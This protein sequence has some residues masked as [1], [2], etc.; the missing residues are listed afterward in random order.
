MI[1]VQSFMPYLTGGAG[2]FLI[3]FVVSALSLIPLMKAKDT[4]TRL[5]WAQAHLF[6]LLFPL[7]W[8]FFF[9]TCETIFMQ[10]A[11]HRLLYVTGLA[12]LSVSMIAI[13]SIPR[14]FVHSIIQKASIANDSLK[15][16]ISQHAHDITLYYINSAKPAAFSASWKK[17]IFL[18]V[19]LCDLLSKKE[20]EAVL[21]HELFHIRHRHSS[22]KIT[23]NAMR[24]FS[25]IVA[26]SSST[27][28]DEEERNADSAVF[29]MQK[30]MRHLVKA[31]L[32][33]E[34]MNTYYS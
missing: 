12:L 30:T 15:D 29:A 10:C 22:L 23:L 2:L 16:F 11:G 14:V 34:Q 13:Y 9:M 27:V 32:K 6:F 4:K 8:Y 31:K 3:S 26:F 20:R 19:G 17:S 33:I 25:P 1:C 18:S 5:F 28:L 21:L 7:F 24:W